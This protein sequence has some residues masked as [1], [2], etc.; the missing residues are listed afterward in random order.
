MALNIEATDSLAGREWNGLRS[1]RRDG[2]V[3]QH[4]AKTDVI[5]A[6]MHRA[7]KAIGG[8]RFVCIQS[9]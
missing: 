1:G 3:L 5:V 8:Q 6:E 7:A 4:H 9:P 2:S